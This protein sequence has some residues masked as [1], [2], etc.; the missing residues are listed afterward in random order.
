M[1]DLLNVGQAC[2]LKTKSRYI[3]VEVEGQYL[4]ALPEDL[5]FRLTKL[6]KNGNTYSCRIRSIRDRSCLVFLKETYQSQK[7]IHLHSFSVAGNSKSGAGDL[8]PI[9][10]SLLR[11]EDIPINII[12]SDDDDTEAGDSPHSLVELSEKS[13]QLN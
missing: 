9:D 4:G 3:S 8:S 7:N 5:S 2:E 10:D 1:F 12:N 11:Q 13:D 6:I